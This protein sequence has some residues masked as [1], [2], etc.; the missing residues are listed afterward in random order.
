MIE[1]LNEGTLQALLDGELDRGEAESARRHLAGCVACEAEYG[2]LRGGSLVFATAV[3]DLDAPARSTGGSFVPRT[4]V[5][6]RFTF[7]GVALQRAAIIV[8]GFTAV[9]AAAAAMP[10]SPIRD[11]LVE[12]LGP[13]REGVLDER[14][15]VPA[16]PAPELARSGV[17]VSPDEGRLRI[18]I[19]RPAPELR[20]RATITESPRGGAYATGEAASARFATGLGL[21][22]VIDARGG[23]LLLEIPAGATSATVELDGRLYLTKDGDQL[24]LLVASGDTSGAEVRFQPR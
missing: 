5:P 1:H 21:V 18:V 22:E 4:R 2:V 8:V 19:V 17:S 12:T 7:F 6:R 23:E 10:G 15:A 20:I 14:A 16:P 9:A 24:R 11:W 3:S 13:L